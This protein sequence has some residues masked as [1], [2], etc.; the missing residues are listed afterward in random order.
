MCDMM[1]VLL[2]LLVF[3]PQHRMRLVVLFLSL[4]LFLPTPAISDT[5]N[6]TATSL[7]R[8]LARITAEFDPSNDSL[9][10]TVPATEDAAAGCR[11][12]TGLLLELWAV[13]GQEPDSGEGRR[14]RPRDFG[15]D[16]YF[17]VEEY[18]KNP[19]SDLLWRHGKSVRVVAADTSSQIVFTHVLGKD[20]NYE[21]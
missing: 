6:C 4:F 2:V 10:V 11:T 13:V 8:L 21:K 20:E 3:C 16:A 17:S 18:C 9:V 12:A 5:S 14:N 19:D 7:K 15:N 1:L